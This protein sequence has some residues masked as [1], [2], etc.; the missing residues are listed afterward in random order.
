ME[1]KNE[2][3]T[4]SAGG[5]I[6]Y[7]TP[8]ERVVCN[9]T[10][11]VYL[12]VICMTCCL[13]YHTSYLHCSLYKYAYAALYVEVYYRC[14]ICRYAPCFYV[15]FYWALKDKFIF[16]L[17]QGSQTA[18]S[19]AE[20]NPYIWERFNVLLRD[21]SAGPM[22]AVKSVWTQVFPLKDSVNHYAILL[23]LFLPCCQYVNMCSCKKNACTYISLCKYSHSDSQ[24]MNISCLF[25]LGI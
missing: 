17:P 21:T 19:A 22:L 7:A 12:Q 23:P 10:I 1:R 8:P 2:Q 14:T 4:T 25:P 24:A 3:K 9:Y 5:T 20:K 11:N 18:A 13:A 6:I 15:I 16:S